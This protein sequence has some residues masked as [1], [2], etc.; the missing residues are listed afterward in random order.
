MT[1]SKPPKA[2]KPTAKRINDYVNRG[3]LPR[4]AAGSSQGLL[5]TM[6]CGRIG[7][8]GDTHGLTRLRLG[9]VFD[10]IDFPLPAAK[11]L[12]ATG[13]LEQPPLALPMIQYYWNNLLAPA[14]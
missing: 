6:T 2:A 13:G 12:I 1:V 5:G 14:P 11:Q 4:S 10:V 9:R 7:R 8:P 3:V